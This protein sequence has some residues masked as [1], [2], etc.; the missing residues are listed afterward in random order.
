[1]TPKIRTSAEADLTTTILHYRSEDSNEIETPRNTRP[2]ATLDT[3]EI[4]VYHQVADITTREV[5]DPLHLS[6]TTHSEDDNGACSHVP[7][8]LLTN[9]AYVA[10]K[11]DDILMGV[12]LAHLPSMEL[13]LGRMFMVIAFVLFSVE[14]W[15]GASLPEQFG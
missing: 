12:L 8:S 4:Q 1:M 9:K 6:A 10:H 15:T 7:Q 5:Q 14:I 2:I 11:G 13:V 3:P